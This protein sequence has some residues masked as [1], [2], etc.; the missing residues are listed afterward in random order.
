MVEWLDK[1]HDRNKIT[2]ERFLSADTYFVLKYT[3]NSIVLLIKYLLK[4]PQMDFV[5]IGK[6]MTDNLE[7]RFGQYK[8]LSG[9][10]SLIPVEEVLQSER[11][12]RVSSLLWFDSFCKGEIPRKEF[13]TEFSSETK[14]GLDENFVKDFPYVKLDNSSDSVNVLVYVAGYVAKNIS[15]SKTDCLECCNALGDKDKPLELLVETDLLSYLDSL[16]RG[17][18]IYPSPTLINI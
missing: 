13:L 12:L 9:A 3:L 11:K 15:M 7:A 8:Q 5:V 6:F 1:W 14:T 2:R 18:L 17:G 16:N 10:N 4:S